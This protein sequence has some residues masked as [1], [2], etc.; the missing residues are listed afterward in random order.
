MQKK[1]TLVTA[2]AIA[3]LFMIGCNEGD[4]KS[5]EEA[6]VVKIDSA[7]VAREFV[8]N[9]RT[10]PPKATA[11]RASD[12]T[13]GTL[14]PPLIEWDFVTKF[15]N[16]YEA[17]PGMMHGEVAVKGFHISEETL[18]RICANDKIKSLYIAFGKQD[19]GT[20]VFL[21]LGKD[22]DGKLYEN[23]DNDANFDF[24]EKCP[25]NCP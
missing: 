24:N 13:G 15:R 18:A 19:D 5:T 11:G 9:R 10:I 17:N 7:A 1:I 3:A 23:D 25:D 4:Q 14:E 12:S 8:S 20:P 2:V 21:V 6:T 22:A 16:N